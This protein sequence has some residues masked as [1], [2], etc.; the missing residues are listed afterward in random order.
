LIFLDLE[1]GFHKSN[2]NGRILFTCFL[3]IHDEIEINDVIYSRIKINSQFKL[4]AQQELDILLSL[5]EAPLIPRIFGVHEESDYLCILLE[6]LSSKRKKP[7]SDKEIVTMLLHSVRTLNLFE[8]KNIA[9]RPIKPSSCLF[10]ELGYLKFIDFGNRE[11]GSLLACL[12]SGS[13]ETKQGVIK[14]FLIVFQC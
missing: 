10:N 4:E 3:G 5:Q 12:F 13:N 11:G 14:I 2:V 6:R 7:H 8:S 9:F 1:P